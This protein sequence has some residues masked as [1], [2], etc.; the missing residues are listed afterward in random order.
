MT[1]AP[2]DALKSADRAVSSEAAAAR[3][4]AL[5]GLIMWVLGLFSSV[6]FGIVLLSILFVYCS[7]G[8]AGLIYPIH[9]NIFSADAW[10]H[11]QIRQFRPFEMTEFEW[12]HWWPF[13]L[14]ILLLCL[15]IAITT[16]RRIRLSVINLGVW[17][18]HTGII[19]LAIGSVIY[20]GRKIEGDAPIARRAVTASIETPDGPR[21][22]SFLASPGNR[23]TLAAG[24]GQWTFEVA[25]I[26]PGWEIRSGDDAG[27]RAYSVNVM[28][29]GPSGRF[30]RQ[31]LADYPA[32]TEDVL[33]TNDP[34]QPMQRAVKATGKPLVDESL[35]LDLQYAPTR[36]FYLKND[37][38][39]S[40]ALYVRRPGDR[41][42][43]ERPIHGLPLYN[44]F[45]ASREDVLT[46]PGDEPP[47]IDPID[48][49]IPPAG[50]DDPFPDV[51]FNA[52]GYLRYATNR[53]T[54]AP[55]PQDG[56]KPPAFSPGLQ[57]QIGMEGG[58][59]RE[60]LMLSGDPQ[61][62]R[63]EEGLI[64]FVAAGSEAELT[65][66]QKPPTLEISVP[67]T[68]F[69]ASVPIT[70]VSIVDP[71]L[72][73]TPAG[74]S[75]I[76]WRV[77]TIEDDIPLG[78]GTASVA[79][80]ELR[81]PKGEFRRWVFD[82]A[83]LTRDVTDE[84]ARDA[85]G[86]AQLIDSDIVIR[87]LPGTGRAV[88]TL[89][90]GP[91]PDAL[92]AIV[93]RSNEPVE[94]RD[95]RVGAATDLGGGL[96]VRPLVYEPS[97]RVLTRPAIVP[98]EQRMRDAGEF[99]AQVKLE[100]PGH[101]ASFPRGLPWIPFHR[102]PFASEQ[103]ALRRFPYQ[104]TTIT[105]A[106]GRRI[107]VL[108]SR[109]RHA[110]PAPVA[111]DEFVLDTHLG[112]FTGEATTVR[113]YTS[114][115]RF[116]EPADGGERWGQPLAVS[117]NDPIQRDGWWFF[118]AQWD[119]PDEARGGGRAS[120]GLNYTVLGVGNREGVWIQLAGC[121]IA[122]VGMIYAFYIKPI[123]K[124]RKAMAAQ[125]LAAAQG[126]GPRRLDL[127]PASVATASPETRP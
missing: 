65:A 72:A 125:A 8:S 89:V 127:A 23:A 126:V 53:T 30:M 69:S 43:V 111:L 85:H 78:T 24:E 33:F 77:R 44:D 88:L 112:G 70:G 121:V 31:L 71:S 6:P 94:V 48:I 20:F 57:F 104:P 29:D 93:S 115:V 34:N 46:M 3:G 118:Q 56:L 50:P 83:R 55:A 11:A 84:S 7:I 123:L 41:D 27:K 61:S 82:D 18:I 40:W 64:R 25:S 105:L 37:A 9:P 39:K 108:F 87:Y 95:L 107:E 91:A 32:Y 117:V 59:S 103:E 36:W 76:S 54:L 122:V 120:A 66:L 17:M 49:A 74:D 119:P 101:Q 62:S 73:F 116:E 79:I 106:D 58:R 99:F 38:M 21:Q 15:N 68:G 81:T 96:A 60:Y 98:R 114:V 113:N 110:L 63:S 124:R 75:G 90:A 52:T 109:Q 47:P 45:I 92:R 4:G 14:L 100:V 102:Y 80:V 97:A 26:D 42:W 5:R 28:I 2:S 10:V 67:S 35:K 1:H 51:T 12:F 86:P 16:V 19:V 13:N 22:V